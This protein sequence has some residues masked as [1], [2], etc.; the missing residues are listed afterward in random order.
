MFPA[1]LGAVYR[2]IGEML[3]PVADHDTAVLFDPVTVGVNSCVPPGSK[4]I[5][6]GETVTLTTGAVGG[7]LP[8]A[9]TKHLPYVRSEDQLSGKTVSPRGPPTL[10]Q[11]VPLVRN[12]GRP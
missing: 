7:L 4:V 5:D 8:N 3:P 1:S 12:T 9:E 2:P 6:V 11:L 10:L